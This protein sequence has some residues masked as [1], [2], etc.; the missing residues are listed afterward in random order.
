[1][2]FLT[3]SPPFPSSCHR[4]SIH[5]LKKAGVIVR[6]EGTKG[7]LEG[8]EIMRNTSAGVVIA[9][10]ADPLLQ[11]CKSVRGGGGQN[12]PVPSCPHGWEKKA[13]HKGWEEELRTGRRGVS[14]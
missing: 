14:R 9:S 2:I 1:M 10:G 5:D 8:C 7:R 11:A 13:V 4:G 12:L 6:G 3:L